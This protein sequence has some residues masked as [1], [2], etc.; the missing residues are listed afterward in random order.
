[1]LNDSLVVLFASS[2]LLVCIGLMVLSQKADWSFCMTGFNAAKIQKS[3]YAVALRYIKGYSLLLVAILLMIGCVVNRQQHR[4]VLIA[5][6]VLIISE[7]TNIYLYKRS[8][9]ID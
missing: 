9:E 2:I 8:K 4:C 6:C 1:M 7:I 3:K 5:L